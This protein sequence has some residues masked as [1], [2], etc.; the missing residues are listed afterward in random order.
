MHV[1]PAL[2]NYN[3]VAS[4]SLK[5]K[6]PEMFDCHDHWRIFFRSSNKQQT[7][8]SLLINFKANYVPLNL[9]PVSIISLT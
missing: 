6:K 1:P 9:R 3:T 7:P 8:Y 5:A 2:P 4:V